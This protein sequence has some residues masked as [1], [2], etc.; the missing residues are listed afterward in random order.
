MNKERGV[1]TAGEAWG[2]TAGR[3]GTDAKD[4]RAD[5]EAL[6]AAVSAG[7]IGETAVRARKIGEN[8]PDGACI[9]PYD[10]HRAI[11]LAVDRDDPALVAALGAAFNRDQK[12]GWPYNGLVLEARSP[13]LYAIERGKPAIAREISGN[14]AVTIGATYRLITLEHAL[15]RREAKKEQARAAHREFALLGDTIA[16]LD[17]RAEEGYEK[18]SFFNNDMWWMRLDADGD[19]AA[20]AEVAG[21]PVAAAKAGYAALLEA[22]EAGD[23]PAAAA[24][25]RHIR[26]NDPAARTVTPGDESRAIWAAAVRDNAAMFDTLVL[27][28]NREAP[29][30]AGRDAPYD[31]VAVEARSPILYAID[32]GKPALA[33]ALARNPDFS[34][35][36]RFLRDIRGMAAERRAGKAGE[37]EAAAREARLLDDVVEALVTRGID[38]ERR[39]EADGGNV[40][41]KAQPVRPQAFPA[42]S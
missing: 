19:G 29:G 38:A 17:K 12:E 9:S 42:L 28:F 16:A 26:K 39:A 14:P 4:V 1:A 34:M 2:K 6:L 33:R 32:R 41:V 5:Y 40:P 7:D 27:A 21:D 13:L 18:S 36:E 35:G 37:Y 20:V 15:N 23:M 11:W 30:G 10:A 8:D 25:V 22:V 31:R 24:V 3:E